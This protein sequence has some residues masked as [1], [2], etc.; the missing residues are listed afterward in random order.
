VRDLR[1]DF[2]ILLSWAARLAP[3]D[4]EGTYVDRNKWLIYRRGGRKN[5]DSNCP[6]IAPAIEQKMVPSPSPRGLL[7][8]RPVPGPGRLT[9]APILG[10]EECQK[11]FREAGR[12]M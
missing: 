8:A 5:A 1:D 10:P 7:I 2:L 9:G 4:R 12:P 6:K 3:I 11:P